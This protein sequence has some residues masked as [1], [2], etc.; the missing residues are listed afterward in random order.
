MAVGGAWGWG[1]SEVAHLTRVI[2]SW[3]R[4]DGPSPMDSLAYKK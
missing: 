4:R 3:E 1:S 2:S